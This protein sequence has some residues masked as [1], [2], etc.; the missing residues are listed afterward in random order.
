MIRRPPRSTLFPY[1]TLFRSA[2][3]LCPADRNPMIDRLLIQLKRVRSEEHSSE[4]QSRENL[5]CRL[6]LEK[7]NVQPVEAVTPRFILAGAAEQRFALSVYPHLVGPVRTG[8][9]GRLQ[10]EIV[11][12]A[13]EGGHLGVT[14]AGHGGAV[15]EDDGLAGGQP[16]QVDPGADTAEQRQAGEA[17]AG[18][19]GEVAWRE[20]EGEL[21]EVD[22]GAVWGVGG[23]VAASGGGGVAAEAGQA[24]AVV[25][26]VG[27]GAG[28]P[29]GQAER[30]AGQGDQRGQTDADG[31]LAAGAEAVPSV[32]ERVQ[33]A[34]QPWERCGGKRVSDLPG[35]GG[36]EEQASCQQ[37]CQPD[38]GWC[39]RCWPTA[40]PVRP[41]GRGVPHRQRRPRC[42]SSS[43]AWNANP[44]AKPSSQSTTA[45]RRTRP[46]TS[47]TST[48]S[49]ISFS[50]SSVIPAITVPAPSPRT[51]PARP[52]NHI[53]TAAITG[54]HHTET[55]NRP[56][57][58]RHETVLVRATTNQAI[59][60]PYSHSQIRSPARNSG[61]SANIT[62]SPA[63]TSHSPTVRSRAHRRA[64][65]GCRCHQPAPRAASRSHHS[66]PASVWPWSNPTTTVVGEATG[67]PLGAAS[68]NASN[69][70][71]LSQT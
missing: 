30:A 56:A 69:Q 2:R 13:A 52:D 22:D 5:V 18:G 58:S 26:Q 49:G 65:H 17:A 53:D 23:Q 71:D 36:G 38:R 34:G 14:K 25:Q 37:C 54:D 39:R 35:G 1:T 47:S 48:A 21:A 67:R 46:G 10:G 9:S 70:S 45:R 28:D 40:G 33:R 3:L 61:Y 42:T 63:S 27:G 66:G 4:L 32:A 64:N 68:T 19:A 20:G 8:A 7:K 43:N 24:V 16:A 50:D 31:D 44:Q 6:L 60:S 51:P 41:A 55:E 57:T 15:G 12:P 59:S 29:E 11:A 62:S